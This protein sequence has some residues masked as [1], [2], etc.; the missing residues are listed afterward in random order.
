MTKRQASAR[1]RKETAN[2]RARGSG[3]KGQR[4]G[5]K[6]DRWTGT[7]PSG[8]ESMGILAS[9]ADLRSSNGT[10]AL[11]YDSRVS[12][13]T[14]DVRDVWSAPVDAAVEASVATSV[15][16]GSSSV[17]IV[18]SSINNLSGSSHRFRYLMDGQ[19][20]HTRRGG[21]SAGEGMVKV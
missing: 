11:L 21:D 5:M 19:R 6:E 7:N 3:Q 10:P 20:A 9:N 18:S 12:F 1:V 16:H 15:W 14:R 17:A 13:R 2:G 4:R 8:L